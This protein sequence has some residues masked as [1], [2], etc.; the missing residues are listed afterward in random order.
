MVDPPFRRVALDTM[1]GWLKGHANPPNSHGGTVVFAFF[2]RGKARA[3][4]Q[5]GPFWGAPG[6]LGSGV[7]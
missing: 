3:P 4:G 5:L 6:P 2:G 7:L 1:G